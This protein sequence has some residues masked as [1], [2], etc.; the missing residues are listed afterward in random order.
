MNIRQFQIFRQD[1]TNFNILEIGKK[2]R[3]VPLCGSS[4]FSCFVRFGLICPTNKTED[5]LNL[6]LVRA[7]RKAD[8]LR[9]GRSWGYEVIPIFHRRQYHATYNI[10]SALL[11]G[12]KTLNS[13][14]GW[15]GD[16]VFIGLSISR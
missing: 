12:W 14:E 15:G 3:D 7:V 6:P 13:P 1:L 9:V 2:N 8:G 5:R 4:L 10:Q 11:W 16:A